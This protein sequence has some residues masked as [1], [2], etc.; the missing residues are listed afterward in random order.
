[1]VSSGGTVPLAATPPF[2]H[3]FSSISPFRHVVDGTRS[4]FYF[5]G[6]LASGLG[7]AW[8]SV[9]VGG[10]LGL[11]LGLVVTTLYGRVHAFSRHPSDA[12]TDR[13]AATRPPGQD[14][15]PGSWIPDQPIHDRQESRRE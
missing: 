8:I 15:T 6:N 14:G 5:D 3:W 12:R 11:L 4:L 10:T 13:G 9:A 7:S 1:M 2:L